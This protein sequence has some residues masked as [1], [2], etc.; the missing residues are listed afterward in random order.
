MSDL[1][2]LEIG[3]GDAGV[4]R[5]FMANLFGWPFHPTKE[6]GPGWFDAPPAMIGLHGDDPDRG[7]TVYF[8]VDDIEAAAARVTELGGQAETPGPAHPGFGRFCRC[9]DPEGVPFGLHQP[10]S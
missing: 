10:E 6:G 3:T 8:R 2:F 9:T 4:T 7:I 1:T 5:A